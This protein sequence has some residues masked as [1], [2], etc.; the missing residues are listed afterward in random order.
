MTLPVTDG[1]GLF[2][3]PF[4]FLS[5]ETVEAFR[6]VMP[7]EFR[8]VW[9]PDALVPDPGLV[10]W[11]PNPGQ[12]FTVSDETLALF[13]AL[14]VIATPSTGRNHIDE[15]ACARRGVAVFSL[16]DDRPILDSIT[17][18]AEF[19]FLLLLNAL[20]RLDFSVG[21][22]TEGRWRAREDMLRGY[23]LAEKHVGIVGFGRNGRRM[24]RFCTAFDATVAY[25]DPYVSSEEALTKP[26]ERIFSESDAVVLCC[27]LTPETTGMV[28]RS[29][30]SL[31]KHRAALV[32]T[33]RGE[34]IQER[35]LV[36][37]LAERSDVRVALDVLAG[38]VTNTH[39]ESPL[40]AYHR[41]GQIV[42]TP[43]IAGATFES[44]NKAAT[45]SLAAL[46]RFFDANA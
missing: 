45:G 26:L 21:E 31:L 11:V 13:P 10:A 12:N 40:L 22:V 18:S 1:H 7:M 44:Q 9:M 4:D 42:I 15:A 30:L 19:T 2:S 20:R 38:E 6:T 33:S 39:H 14:R 36:D 43:H 24:A 27:A 29:L 46:C 41:S 5:T 23:E 8:E 17:A 28:D 37:L 16:Q 25:Y 3:A 34:V 32:N 35:D